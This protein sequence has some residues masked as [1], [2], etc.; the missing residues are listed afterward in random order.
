MSGEF[1]S[2]FKET[3]NTIFRIVKSYVKSTDTAKDIVL[4]VMMKVYQRWERVRSFDNKTGYA[5]RI[6]IN[7]AKKYLMD[8]KVKSFIPFIYDG[9]DVEIASHYKNPE[10][11]M[12][13]SEEEE[14]LEKELGN[15]KDIERE[16]I[17]LKDI[18]RKKF[19]EIAVIFNKKLPTIKS[20][21]RRGKIKL[22]RKLEEIY[23]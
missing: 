10:A 5:V 7:M 1:E 8:N 4:E 20:H 22:S 6:G 16:I 17:L 13:K 23:D 14:W 19:E 3:E 12:I 11:S 9:E 21:Y 15:L 18:D 2:F